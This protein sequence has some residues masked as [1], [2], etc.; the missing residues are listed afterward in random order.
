MSTTTAILLLLSAAD[1][2]PQWL[3]PRR[4]GVWRETGIVSKFPP[5]GP[6]ALWRTPIAGGY[7]GP[8]VSDGK[9]F[10]TDRTEKQ[11]RVLCLDAKDGR[12]LWTHAY[13]CAYSISY[14]AGPRTTPVVTADRV[15]ALGAMGDLLCLE[16]ATGK[17]VWSRSFVKDY[18]QSAPVWGWSG[19]PLLD[20][21]RLICTVGG[22]GTAVVAFHKDTGKELW[23]AQ[24]SEGRHGPGYAP[25][26]IFEAG[27]KRQLIAWHA[28]ALASLD[29]ETGREHW[30]Q[31]FPMREGLC[32]STP[33]LSGDR[34]FV[35]SFYNGPLMM[36]LGADAPTATVLWKGKSQ[37]EIRTDGL[38]SIM[39]TPFV[40]DGH[41][42][43]VCS[44]GQLR[45]LKEE[46]GE[47]VWETFKATTGDKPVRW[48]N[49]FIVPQGDRYFLFN[50]NGDLLIAR[51]TPSGYEEIDRAHLVEPTNQAGFMRKTEPVVWSHP[52]FAGRCVFVRNDREIACFSLSE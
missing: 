35:T 39:S 30:A 26:V 13:D 34:L 8:A 17:P 33:R 27:G 9:V 31:P 28:Q 24:D 1:D 29:P 7:A 38:H 20:A 36:K 18:G 49:A 42:Y 19:H 32:I 21:D 47:R 43:G 5:G 6:K 11:E 22:K 48:A 14:P 50:E 10:V 51:L 12:V 45:C 37:N 40:R 25:P 2:W 46:T 44:Y 41:I 3:G 52:A 16:R 4:D 15:Y 23:R